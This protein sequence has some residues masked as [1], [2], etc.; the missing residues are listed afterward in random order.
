MRTARET[1]SVR[2]SAAGTSGGTNG[3]MSDGSSVSSLE[4]ARGADV[5]AAERVGVST[6]ATG[7]AACGADHRISR[8]SEVCGAELRGGITVSQCRQNSSLAGL[9]WPFGHEIILRPVLR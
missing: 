4:N 2:C 8:M 9:G 7:S 1:G 3:V 6:S 5:V